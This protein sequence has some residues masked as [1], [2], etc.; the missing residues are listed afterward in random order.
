M[1][2]LRKQISSSKEMMKERRKQEYL[3]NIERNSL[4]WCDLNDGC[5]TI[6]AG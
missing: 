4:V 2:Q 1:G 6:Q 5:V 3:R